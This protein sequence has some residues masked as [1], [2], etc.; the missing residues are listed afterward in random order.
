MQKI[1]MSKSTT[2]T[3][4]EAFKLFIRKCEVK[5]LTELSI[6]SYRKKIVHFYEFLSGEET[7]EQITSDTVDDL[8][9]VA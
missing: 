7:I 3:I 5:N 6:E 1:T 4:E 2:P 9:P 8:Y